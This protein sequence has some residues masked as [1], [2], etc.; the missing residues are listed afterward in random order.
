MYWPNGRK[1][2]QAARLVARDDRLQA[3]YLGNFRCGP[4]SFISH[5]VREELRGKPYLQV[6]MDEHSADAGLITRL[7]AFLGSLRSRKQ[8]RPEAPSRPVPA[9]L[10]AQSRGRTRSGISDGR[11][12]YFP[13]MADGA[14]ALA[15]ACRSCG[16][17]AD[18]LPPLNDQDLALGRAHTSSRECF[19]MIC[20]TGSFLRKLMEPGVDPGSVSFFMPDHNGPCRFGQ[21]NR[22]QRIIFDRLGFSD[23]QIVHPSNED[24][25]AG[26]IPRRGVRFRLAV[27]RGVIA[28]DILRKLLQERSPYEAQAGASR[29]VYA[30]QLRKVIDCIEAGGWGIEKVLGSAIAA[31]D[32]VAVT[33]GQRKPVISVIGEIYMRDNAFC[34]GYVVRR[35]ES[36][37]AETFMGPVRDWVSYSTWRYTRDS[38][39]KGRVLGFVK[40]KVQGFFQ[41]VIEERLIHIAARGGVEMHRD[42][43]LSRMMDLCSPYIHRDYDGDPVLALGGAAAQAATGISGVVNI[44]PF[45]CLP[46][47]VIAA[48]SPQFCQDHDGIPWINIAYDGQEDSSMETRLQAFIYRAKEFAGRKGFDAPRKWGPGH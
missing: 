14:H 22:L 11:T 41:E 47:T 28:V 39:R 30:D 48:A 4:D 6:E 23:T 18:V 36:L 21:Y 46:G 8:A 42:A 29:A 32:S 20:T 25:Y 33:A 40:S 31:F 27:W 24:S 44:L 34:N 3:V 19:P 1:I 15:A 9:P 16:V 26:L 45:T 17:K 13:Y 43:T 2:I 37:G 7:E 38:R 12:L 10:P 35:L 5:Y